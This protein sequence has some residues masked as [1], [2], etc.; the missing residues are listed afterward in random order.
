MKTP[1][2]GRLLAHAWIIATCVLT[3]LSSVESSAASLKAEDY[4]SGDQLAAYRLAQQGKTEQLAKAAK[5]VDLNLPGKQDLTLLGLAVITADRSA[6]V[7]LM[8]AGANPNQVIPNAGSPAILAITHHFNP[9]RTKALG[10]LFDGGYDLNQLLSHG[11]PYMFYFIKYN[12][13]P[14]LELALKR[15]GNI[16]IRRSN[17]KSLLTYVIEGGDYS[18]A[19]D[20]ISKGADVTARGE[21]DETALEAIEFH[22]TRVEPSIREVWKEVVAM[23]KLILSKL[24]DPKD[25]RSAFTDRAE[26][27]IRQNP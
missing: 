3:A 7:S 27:K 23:R 8:R 21:R 15:G 16:N 20:L 5:T 4:F 1:T 10:A 26:E 12:H 11:T 17:G 6:I 2:L 19:R 24:P 22:V 18:Q 25:R 14:G 13:W 9:P